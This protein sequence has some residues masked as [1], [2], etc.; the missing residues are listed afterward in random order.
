MPLHRD[1]HWIGR[2]WAVTGHGL[3]LI[4]QKQQGVFDIEV[5]KLWDD[6]LIDSIHAKEWL[7]AAD[8]Y[9]GLTIAR[10]RF[11]QSPDAVTPPPEIA[12]PPAVAPSPP[13]AAPAPPKLE[14]ALPPEQPKPVEPPRAARVHA[15][16]IAAHVSAAPA[17]PSPAR[18][19]MRFAGRAR[20]V[21][22][23]RVLIKR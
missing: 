7:N 4:D 6:D 19:E 20:F 9:K 22:P 11:E 17:K 14:E 23:W 3:Q 21:R 1:I 5:S 2:Q 10:A 16:S 18:F 15:P 13:V 8:F 12:L